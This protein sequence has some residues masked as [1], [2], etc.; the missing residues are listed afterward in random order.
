MFTILDLFYLKYSY[1][2]LL[3]P[4]VV[5]YPPLDNKC[6]PRHN[7]IFVNGAYGWEIVMAIFTAMLDLTRQEL[8]SRGNKL[9]KLDLLLWSIGLSIPLIA[10]YT[11]FLCLQSYV[12]RLDVILN[13]AALTYLSPQ[14]LISLAL[15]KLL[16]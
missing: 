15:A 4:D 3:A 11:F 10:G 14:L 12:L 5:V 8:A 16:Y 2:F 7:F 1:C 13:V 9:G 6:C